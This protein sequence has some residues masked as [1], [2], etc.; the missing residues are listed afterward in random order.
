MVHPSGEEKKP[1]VYT[2]EIKRDASTPSPRATHA[3]ARFFAPICWKDMRRPCPRLSAWESQGAWSASSSE[4][5]ASESKSGTIMSSCRPQRGF[6]DTVRN[7]SI[8]YHTTSNTTPLLASHTWR[9]SHQLKGNKHP[10][11]SRH[12]VQRRRQGQ[13]GT[14]TYNVERAT[15]RSGVVKYFISISKCRVMRVVKEGNRCRKAGEY[16]ERHHIYI[17]QRERERERWCVSGKKVNN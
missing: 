15:R 5:H 1:H 2:C 16:K 10:L 6:R 4:T 7:A 13:N 11:T 12:I 3:C 9:T 17:M 14:S 8:Q